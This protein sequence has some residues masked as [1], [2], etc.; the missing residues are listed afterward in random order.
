MVQFKHIKLLREKKKMSQ[1]ELSK[2]IGVHATLISKIEA[3]DSDGSIATLQKIA[4]ALGV[5]VSELLD[6][7]EVESA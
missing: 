1:V 4:A 3:G 7:S 6:E 2:I 5:P